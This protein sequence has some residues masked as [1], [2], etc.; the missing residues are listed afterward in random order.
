MMSAHKAHKQGFRQSRKLADTFLK[1]PDM[2]PDP[3]RGS[4]SMFHPP[5]PTKKFKIEYSE[6]PFSA[7]LKP[8]NPGSQASLEFTL[9]ILFK[10]FN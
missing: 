9:E 8:R 2:L 4:G 5:P 3:P 10:I 1:V 6:T 7:F